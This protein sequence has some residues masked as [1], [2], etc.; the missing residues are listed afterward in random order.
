MPTRLLDVTHDPYV[1]LF[2][3]SESVSSIK[4]ESDAEN[5]AVYI[6]DTSKN[7]SHEYHDAPNLADNP[8]C[9]RQKGGFMEM[10]HN[11]SGEYFLKH[12]KWPS[13]DDDMARG[14]IQKIVFPSSI[15]QAIRKRLSE[16]RYGITKSYLMPSYSNVA[17]EVVSDLKEEY[18]HTKASEPKGD[19][20][21]DFSDE[22]PQA[23]SGSVESGKHNSA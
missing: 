19:I 9:F 8:F 14:S 6:I 11:F 12:G 23:V 20:N 10:N 22:L 2:F 18:L 15:A 21:P 13:L 4:Q 3:A 1:A 7:G 16:R 17:E 5:R